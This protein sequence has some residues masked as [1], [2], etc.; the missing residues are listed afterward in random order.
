[1]TRIGV[2]AAR[3]RLARAA[4]AL[5]LLLLAGCSGTVEVSYRP[6]P[7][8][9]PSPPPTTAPPTPTAAPTSEAPVLRCGPDQVQIQVGGV[10]ANPNSRA[11][12]LLISVNTPI[13]CRVTN[14][15]SIE[16]LDGGGKSLTTR[17]ELAELPAGRTQVDSVAAGGTAM[18]WLQWRP[19]PSSAEAD[20]A[21]DCSA[22]R[23]LRL[24]LTEKAPPIPVAATI[25]AC[26]GGTIYVSPAEASTPG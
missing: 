24:S 6:P 9:P 21:T 15:V 3:V 5:A 22:A 13:P 20:P 19:D 12:P 4:V 11:V 18:V 2:A 25:T 26:N 16:L 17:V 14:P 10:Q 7:P 8:P 23:S 1:M